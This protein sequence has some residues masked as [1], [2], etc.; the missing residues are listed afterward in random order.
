MR[1]RCQQENKTREVQEGGACR[2]DQEGPLGGLVPQQE[3]GAPRPGETTSQFECVQPSFGDPPPA[4]SSGM[5]VPCKD[6]EC[7]Q[8]PPRVPDE[9]PDEEGFIRDQGA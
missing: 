7:E 2:Q 6:Q 9:Q 4:V 8:T 3:D 5:L 1:N